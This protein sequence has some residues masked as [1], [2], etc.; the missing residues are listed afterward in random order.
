MKRGRRY[1]AAREKVEAGKDY[2][3]EDAL[4][5]VKES[6]KTKFDETVDV[7]MRLNVDPRHADQMVRGAIA[8]P[9]GTGKETRVLVLTR[10]E[11][12]KDA[13][14]AGADYVGADEY[15]EQIEKGWTDFDVVIATPDIMRDVGKLGRVLGP[16]GLMPNPKSGTVTFDVGPAVREVKAG[17]I[18]YR[19]DR[20]GNLHGP[21]GKV[22]FSVEQLTENAS[23]FIDAV[24][25]AKPAS[26]KG[27]YIRR[28]TVSSA[29][30]PGVQVDRQAAAREA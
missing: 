4:T 11:A 12:Q 24:M 13:Q 15:I 26:A 23:T 18:E 21:V 2:P 8:L 27:Q 30:G 16:R 28:L 25:R 10:G 29:M 19:V 22:S 9:H 3:L 1:L 7:A 17:R 5:I 20:N 6:S 14:E